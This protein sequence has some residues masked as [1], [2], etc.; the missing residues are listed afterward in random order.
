MLIKVVTIEFELNGDKFVKIMEFFTHSNLKEELKEMCKE[1]EV[2]ES[3]CTYQ[4]TDV[5]EKNI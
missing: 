1:Y 2:F 3:K 5:V 4:I